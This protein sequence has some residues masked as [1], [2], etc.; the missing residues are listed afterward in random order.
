[1]PAA[2]FVDVALGVAANAITALIGAAG[3]VF[4]PRALWRLGGA[5]RLGE[6]HVYASYRPPELTRGA[7]LPVM[8]VGQVQA[9]AALMP[10]LV[11]S[12]GW[13]WRGAPSVSAARP[14]IEARE[15]QGNIILLGGQSR[16]EATRKL[17]R[18]CDIGVEQEHREATESG[19][20]IRVR[21]QAGQWSTWLG[22]LN[23]EP[24]AVSITRD[25]GLIVRVPNPWDRDSKGR[26]CL[27]FAGAHTWGTGAAAAFFVRQ[28]WKPKWWARRGFVALIEVEVRDGLVVDST[29]VFF[30]PISSRPSS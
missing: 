18:E 28:W 6:L 7:D 13:R 17:L 8:G 23:V 19:D 25:Y 27:V 14:G 9:L 22:G 3:F 29:C 20:V 30:R 10:S 16:N 15:L 4:L 21:D 1:V 24:T 11:R 2:V 5:Q 12:Y 26:A